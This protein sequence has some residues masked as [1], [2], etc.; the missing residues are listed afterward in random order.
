MTLLCLDNSV[1][2]KFARPDPDSSVVSYLQRNA[3][4][5]WAIPATVL[6]EYLRYYSEA[7]AV[8][9]H[10]HALTQRIERVLPLT[11]G[12]A[13]EAVLLEHS[14]D[15]QDIRLN[16]ADL[17]HA[18]TAREH[19]ATFVTCDAAAFGRAPVQE[20]LEIDIVDVGE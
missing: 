2:A 14:L 11:E 7:S 17:L 6:F 15:Q 1:V 20:L 8:H 12:V 16:L 10:H 13:V 18:A 19:D 9:Q 5:A 3:S 4:E